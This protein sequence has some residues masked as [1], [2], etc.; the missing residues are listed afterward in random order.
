M[1]SQK[2][3]PRRSGPRGAV[4]TSGLR[5][6]L[7]VVLLL[8]GILC[9][10]SLYLVAT[11]L[12]AWI[13]GES[14]EDGLYLWAFLAHLVLGLMILVPFV[15]YGIGHARRGRFRRYCRSS[16]SKKEGHA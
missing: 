13:S 9:I 16:L 6:W 7:R 4:V 14:R 2:R 5:W 8:F 1:D 3:N 10:D 15:I 12:A 11:D